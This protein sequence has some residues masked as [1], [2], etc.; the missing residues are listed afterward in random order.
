MTESQF[1][2]QKIKLLMNRH[3]VTIQLINYRRRRKAKRKRSEA[4]AKNEIN[5]IQL[6]GTHPIYIKR[7]LKESSVSQSRSRGPSPMN[8]NTNL[9]A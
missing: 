9:R 5:L 4:P 1:T 7:S 6:K 3:R 2:K 8:S